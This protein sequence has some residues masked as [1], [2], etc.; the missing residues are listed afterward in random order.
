[1]KMIEREASAVIREKERSSMFFF[2]AVA[3]MH[4]P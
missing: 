3:K 2:W 4:A 1:M